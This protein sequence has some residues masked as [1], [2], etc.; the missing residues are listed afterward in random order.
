M[1][2]ASDSAAWRRLDA[3]STSARPLRRIAVAARTWTLLALG[4]LLILAASLAPACTGASQR[5]TGAAVIAVG[6]STSLIWDTHLAV[7]REASARTRSRIHA[8]ATLTTPEAR[9]AAFDRAMVEVN[10]SF[11]Q[12]TRLLQTM[13]TALYGAAAILDASRAGRQADGGSV[14]S[15][16]ALTLEVLQRTLTLLQEPSG[17]L[18][19]LPIPAGIQDAVR[20]LRQLAGTAP[21][22]VP[23][24]TLTLDGGTP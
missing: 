16:A 9:M 21:P 8:D 17:E 14:A 13:S 23:S 20:S 15:A 5:T 19:P 4:V 24:I 12:R 1:S 11:D 2:T 18:A 7:Y 3:D 10:R 22:V 6:A